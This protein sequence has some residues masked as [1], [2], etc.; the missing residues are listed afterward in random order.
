MAETLRTAS[1]ES[2][3]TAWARMSSFHQTTAFI[4]V[5]ALGWMASSITTSFIT[6]NDGRIALQNE[7]VF[8]A[9]VNSLNE[10]HLGSA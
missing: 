7:N 1:L 6:S 3:N 5:M 9:R 10:T 4:L 8:C 2:H